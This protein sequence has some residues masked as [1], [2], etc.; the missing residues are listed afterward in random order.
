M[1][2]HVGPTHRMKLLYNSNGGQYF[3]HFNRNSVILFTPLDVPFSIG[4]QVHI[5]KPLPSSELTDPDDDVTLP[6]LIEEL[7][8]RHNV[9]LMMLEEDNKEGAFSRSSSVIDAEFASR[10][11]GTHSAFIVEFSRHYQ[12]CAA[13]TTEQDLF[14]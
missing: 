4:Q 1:M 10:I 9:R 12:V 6:K 2:G 5:L 7:R 11:S 14:L 3:L 13:A 8:K